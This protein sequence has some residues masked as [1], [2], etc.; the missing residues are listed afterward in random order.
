[1][2]VSANTNRWSYSPHNLLSVQA[3][4]RRE[5]PEGPRGEVED[6][7]KGLSFSTLDRTMQMQ[8]TAHSGG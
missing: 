1:M 8:P 2:A 5:V 3:G 7:V 4:E 6:L